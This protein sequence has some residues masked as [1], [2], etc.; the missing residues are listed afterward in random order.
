MLVEVFMMKNIVTKGTPIVHRTTVDLE[1]WF[2][3]TRKPSSLPITGT[4]ADANRRT[5][6]H[7]QAFVRRNDFRAT[8]CL[9]V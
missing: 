3:S 4:I 7:K 8:E 1:W 5:I 9:S 2:L 6:Y